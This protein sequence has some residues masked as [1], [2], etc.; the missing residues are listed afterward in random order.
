VPPIAT[1]AMAP[2][3]A[4]AALISATHWK[5]SMNASWIARSIGSRSVLE[6]E[7]G[8]AKS[9]KPSSPDATHEER[10]TRSA[11]LAIAL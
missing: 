11:T 2:V 8:I 6:T 3:T 4:Q 5:L 7:S 9:A 1:I 10:A